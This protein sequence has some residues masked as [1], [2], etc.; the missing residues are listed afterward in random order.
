MIEEPREWT[1]V[2]RL[3]APRLH[4]LAVT[5]IGAADAHD[6]VADA[7]LRAVTSRHWARVVVPG[8]YLTRTLVNLAHDRRRQR[9]RRHSRE[10][11]SVARESDRPS[12]VAVEEIDVQRALSSLS[13]AQLSVVHLHYWED[14]SLQDIARLLQMN[15]GT[16]RSHL[17]R[18]KGRL[19]AVLR[20]TEGDPT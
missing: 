19:R 12:T 1:D 13:S 7:V 14:L 6:L 8:A 17:E 11:R 3:H 9:D 2:Y 4:R 20:E 15:V 10:Q 5:L 18:A 16:V